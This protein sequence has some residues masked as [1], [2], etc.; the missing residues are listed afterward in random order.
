[1]QPIKSQESRPVAAAWKASRTSNDSRHPG[2]ATITAG[3]K[4]KPVITI[5]QRMRG[6]RRILFGDGT[7]AEAWAAPP[8]LCL[9]ASRWQMLTSSAWEDRQGSLA[10]GETDNLA[11]C[12]CRCHCH[13]H[14]AGIARR[15]SLVL[16]LIMIFNKRGYPSIARW[17]RRYCPP[18]KMQ[19]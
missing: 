18:V 16:V 4:P 5:I 15:G 9:P 1:M 11:I 7:V 8:P 2:R 6:L 12:H 14:R 19:K 17:L 10:G 13:A 3:P